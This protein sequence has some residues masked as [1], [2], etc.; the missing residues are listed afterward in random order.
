MSRVRSGV[1]RKSVVPDNRLWSHF[2]MTDMI[3]ATQST[4]MTMD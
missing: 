4:G 1:S 3:Q 2:S